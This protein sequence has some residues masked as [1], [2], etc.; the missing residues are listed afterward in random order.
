MAV[1]QKEKTEAKKKSPGKGKQQKAK[2]MPTPPPA[3]VKQRTVVTPWR[4]TLE[5]KT[6]YNWLFGKSN[7][8]DTRRRALSNIRI[9]GLRRGNLCPAAVLA[10]SVLV[11]A[12]LED[13]EGSSKIQD[14]YA[15]AFTRFYNF[16][17][18]IIQG[19]NMTSMYETAKELGLQSFIVDLRHLCAHGQE[20][21]PVEVLRST[22]VHCLEWLR[23]YYWLPHKESMSNL[24]AGKLHRKDKIKFEKAVTNLLEIYDL[25]LE[26]HFK[27]AEKLKAISKLKSSGEFN[28]IRVYSSSK[29][30]KT[31]TEI[32]SAVLGDLSALVKRESSSMKDLLDIYTNCLLKMEYFLGVGLQIDD[33]EDVLIAATQGLFRLLAVQGYIE[34]VFVA[35]VQLTENQNESEQRRLGASYWATKMVESFGMLFRMKRMYKGELDLNNKLKP[36][37][38]ATLNTDKISK[39][40]R[41]LLVHSNV[42]PSVT[43]IFGDNP[44]KARS[45]VFE[46]EFIMQ[47]VAPFSNY[48]API[49]KGLLPLADPPFTKTQIED[50]TK[51][52][53]TRLQEFEM[54]EP[55]EEDS[56]P[57]ESYNLEYLEKLLGQTAQSSAQTSDLG[58]WKLD[59][60]NDWSKC[61]LGVLPWAQ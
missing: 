51:L 35:L 36:V 60:H 5:F 31:S 8:A 17:S 27:G 22:S 18:S 55:M 56:S 4:D 11:E 42:D 16:M 29:K 24:D 34:K 7:T 54:E 57:E 61:A 48:S 2:V 53:D 15:S 50:L 46:R 39:T 47:R 23:T 28:K 3:N 21:P 30:V 1:A 26:C 12:Q 43:L 45:L 33:N 25:T 58:A 52:C 14:T 19:H 37:D 44:K 20:L 32:L 10:T 6:T 9:W 13:Q 41:S 59:N 40:L 38:F 49:L